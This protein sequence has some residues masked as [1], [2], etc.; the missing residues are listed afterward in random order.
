MALISVDY[1]AG[2]TAIALAANSLASSSDF[3]VGR[4]S[5]RVDNTTNLYVDALVMGTVSVGTTPTINTSINVYVWGSYS[6]FTSL[7]TIGGTD[8]T[9]TLTSA[10]MRDGFMRLAATMFV[11][12]TTSNRTYYYGPVSVATALGLTVLPPFWGIYISQNTGVAL[13]ASN[14]AGQQFQGIKQSVI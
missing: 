6:A 4:Q 10:G 13:H 8:A 3:S 2:V 9:V 14:T 1:G 12:S 11:D 7:D 5:T